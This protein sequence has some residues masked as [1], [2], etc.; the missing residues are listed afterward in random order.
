MV[1]TDKIIVVR[2]FH[3]TIIIPLSFLALP[4][5]HF[6]L[7]QFKRDTCGWKGQLDKTRSWKVLSWKVRHE[8]V[9]N[10]VEKFAPKLE[11]SHRS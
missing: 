9:K 1:F 3:D 6:G 11:S 10:E 8:I 2:E 7:N 5:F 4:L